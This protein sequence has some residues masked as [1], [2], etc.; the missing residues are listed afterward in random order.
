M[1]NRHLALVLMVSLG[2]ILALQFLPWTVRWTTPA[3]AVVSIVWLLCLFDFASLS[4][5]IRWTIPRFLLPVLGT[6]LALVAMALLSPTTFLWIIP[7][8]FISFMRMPFWRALAWGVASMMVSQGI[9]LFVW[10]VDTAMLVRISASGYFSLVVFA[11]F[12]NA[13]EKTRQQLAHTADVLE[14]SLQSMGQ[15]FFRVQPDGRVVMFNDQVLAMLDLPKAL[16]E[17]KPN[18]VDIARFQ[19]TRGDFGADYAALQPNGRDFL[20]ALVQGLH[21][22]A[23]TRYSISTPS[24]RHLDVQC[25]VLPSGDMVKTYT[26]VTEYEVAKAQAEAA[27]QAK[28]QFL[29]NM[30]HEIRTPMN[31]II[32]LTHM[33]QR[34]A[35]RADQ[36]DRLE[37][38][39]SAA[40][41]LLEVINDILDFSKIEAGRMELEFADFDPERVVE[42]ACNI[43]HDRLADKGLELVLDL[44]ALPQTLHGDGMR[45]GQ[46]LLNLLGNAVKFTDAGTLLVRGHVARAADIGMRVRFEVTDTGIGMTELQ[47]AGLFQAFGQADVSTTRKY[48]GSGLGLAIS[49]RMIE[50][51]GGEIG[52]ISAPGQGSTFWIEVPFGFGVAPGPAAEPE[53]DTRGLRVL[54]AERVPEAREALTEM[55]ERQGMRVTASVDAQDL[56]A[57][58]QLAD[59]LGQPFDLLLIEY[60]Q[61][62]LDVLALGSVLSGLALQKQALRLLLVGYDHQ[63]SAAQLSDSGYCGVLQKPFSPTRVRE[64]LQDALSGQPRVRAM[65]TANSA[66][67]ALRRRGGGHVLLVEDNAINQLIALDLLHSVGFTADLAENG[68]IGVEKAAANAYELILLDMMM[69]VM[70]GLDAA[71]AIRQL[72]GHESTPILAMTANAFVEDREACIRAGMNDHIAKP[73]NPQV[74]YAT[75]LRWL[76]QERSPASLLSASMPATP[77]AAA[78]QEVGADATGLSRLEGIAGLDVVDGMERVGD[79]DLYRQLLMILVDSTDADQLCLSL[80]EQ[81]FPT[82]LRA[83]HS[84]RGVAGTLGLKDVQQ[85]AGAVEVQIRD[86]DFD[87]AAVSLSAQTLHAQYTLIVTAIR[88]ALSAS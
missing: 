6:G 33:L 80:A 13:S 7:G 26:D 50:L 59:E 18:L 3:I 83:A 12:F 70:G 31:A 30:S 88:D 85:Q 51:M 39:G 15:G 87:V 84:L 16:L 57:A 67:L 36:T 53:F 72:A 46:I 43:V 76:P 24:G 4:N 49:R 60:P 77:T 69:P 10:H 78:V 45:L 40:D 71:A 9:A 25:H 35:P 20:K 29:A 81:D 68:Q 55:L 27:S 42:S 74:L 82:A 75:L 1:A 79:P 37:K 41:H 64:A 38:I 61:A 23:P 65:S 19:Q 62:A 14:A 28:S 48:G 2:M 32:G 56:V 11:L 86:G 44:R 54:L 47:Q 22:S 17:A 52:V 66:E 5:W 8:M 58:V 21:V 73:V 63:P 34:D